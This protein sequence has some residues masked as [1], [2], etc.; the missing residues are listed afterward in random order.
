MIRDVPFTGDR[1]V[2]AVGSILSVFGMS[3]LVLGVLSW[4]EGGESVGVLMAGGVICSVALFRWLVRRKRA[5]K[6]P[7]FDPELFDAKLFNFG[8]RQSVLQQIA[9]GGLMIALPIYFQLDLEYNALESGLSLAP[10]SLTMFV[11]ALVVGRR[12]GRRRPA[13]LV[14]AGFGLMGVGLVALI[15]VIPSSDTAWPLAVPLMFCGAG[16]GLIVSQL[17]NYALA[18]MSEEKVGEAA[19]VNSAISSFALSFGL[20]MA[21]AIMLATL[22]I[23]FSNKADASAVLPAAD[24]EHIA[25]VLDDD[26]QVMSDS[27]LEEQLAGQP[28]RIQDE[29]VGINEDARPLALQVALMAP[30]LAAALGFFFSFQMMRLPDPAP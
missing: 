29:I 8:I 21:G 30:L 20:A 4:Q 2:D 16:L 6:A 13:F 3:L 10:L 26:A 14:R 27:G 28:P 17:N 22:S 24:K 15:A 5:R 23:A 18:P 19:G 12:T 9:L 25:D 7:L 1:S 11:T